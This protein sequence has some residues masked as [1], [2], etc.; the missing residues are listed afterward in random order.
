MADESCIHCGQ[1]AEDDDRETGSG[2]VHE[3]C[4]AALNS[5][6]E[7]DRDEPRKKS[8]LANKLLGIFV[9]LIAVGGAVLIFI[10]TQGPTVP[11]IEGFGGTQNP[12]VGIPNVAIGAL[13]IFEVL[14]FIAAGIALLVISLIGLAIW[15]FFDRSKA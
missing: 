3:R 15:K 13:G 1:P 10:G 6:N 11:L 9:V 7:N 14:F 12:L 5:A 2:R 8:S 4:W